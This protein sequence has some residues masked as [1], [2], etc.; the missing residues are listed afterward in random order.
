MRQPLSELRVHCDSLP[1]I[2]EGREDVLLVDINTVYY[3]HTAKLCA[4]NV[5]QLTQFSSNKHFIPLN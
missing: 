3:L 1:N 5:E 2:F 4:K